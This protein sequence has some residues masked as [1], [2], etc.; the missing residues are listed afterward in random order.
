[1]GGFFVTN[2]LD[3]CETAR[4]GLVRRLERLHV[5][6]PRDLPPDARRLIWRVRNTGYR[7]PP[8]LRGRVEEVLRSLAAH[9]SLSI[10][11]LQATALRGRLATLAY[12]IERL[13]PKVGGF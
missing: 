10:G 1:M 13:S 12:G 6:M 3:T 5:T 9:L 2:A 4:K 7:P 8:K 11:D